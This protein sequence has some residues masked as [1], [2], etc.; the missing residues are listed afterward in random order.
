MN[1]SNN[2]QP[3]EVFQSNLRSEISKIHQQKAINWIS[4]YNDLLKYKIIKRNFGSLSSNNLRRSPVISKKRKLSQI[5][6]CFNEYPTDYSRTFRLF[7]KTKNWSVLSGTIWEESIFKL[8]KKQK[9]NTS[10]INKKNTKF[11]IKNYIK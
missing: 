9:F 1:H 3:N 10:K 4:L 11:H 5:T 6:I 2:I 8:W 7:L